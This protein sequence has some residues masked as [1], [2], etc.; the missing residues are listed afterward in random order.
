MTN[1]VWQRH[2]SQKSQLWL[3]IHQAPAK[4]CTLCTTSSAVMQWM[5]EDRVSWACQN[6]STNSSDD[7]L[8]VSKVDLSTAVHCLNTT[9]S[10]MFR[11]RA[12]KRISLNFVTPGQYLQL[13]RLQSGCYGLQIILARQWLYVCSSTYITLSGDFRQLYRKL[14]VLV[15]CTN[16]DGMSA[17]WPSKTQC[18]G[19]SSANFEKPIA[20]SR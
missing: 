11:S 19:R 4:I 6:R 1:L 12:A 8:N 7:M 15:N 13:R 10:I 3:A 20:T 9:L 18:L 14:H 5:N 2:N 16:T 17:T